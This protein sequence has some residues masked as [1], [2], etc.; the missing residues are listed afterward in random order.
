M[1]VA[2]EGL[3]WM[4]RTVLDGGVYLR[5]VG[6]EKRDVFESLCGSEGKG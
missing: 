4:D 6:E 3:S 1:R 2:V 5:S